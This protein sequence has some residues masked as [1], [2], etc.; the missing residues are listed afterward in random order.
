MRLYYYRKYFKTFIYIWQ[1]NKHVDVAYYLIII[2]K[3][4]DTYESLT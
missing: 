1:I 3:L 2:N 4:T